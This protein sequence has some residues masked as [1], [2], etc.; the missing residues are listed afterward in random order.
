MWK[1]IWIVIGK[2]R[3]GEKKELDSEKDKAEIKEPLGTS[4]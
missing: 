4:D 3:H 1:K 2:E